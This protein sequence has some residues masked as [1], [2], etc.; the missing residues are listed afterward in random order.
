M[1]GDKGKVVL[2][3]FVD[4]FVILSL[5]DSLKMSREERRTIL[6]HALRRNKAIE[7]CRIPL[8]FD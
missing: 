1:D 7:F 3:Y 2:K 5:K 8:P 4:I 6:K